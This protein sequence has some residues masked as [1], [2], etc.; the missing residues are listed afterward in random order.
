MRNRVSPYLFYL[1]NYILRYAGPETQ[2]VTEEFKLDWSTYLC[3]S[4]NV[5]YAS[6]DG[7]G[8]AG[9]G[10]RFMHAI[11]KKLGQKEVQDQIEGAR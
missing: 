11:Y 6:F 10:N 5:I 2:Q 8:S 7:R 4:E 9:R 1:V 3:S